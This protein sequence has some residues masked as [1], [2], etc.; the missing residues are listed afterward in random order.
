M[1]TIVRFMYVKT[2]VM[3]IK[4]EFTENSTVELMVNNFP[5]LCIVSEKHIILIVNEILIIL[6]K[7]VKHL[8]FRLCIFL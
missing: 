3:E 5:E 6:I 4:I 7:E 8:P 1:T 2:I